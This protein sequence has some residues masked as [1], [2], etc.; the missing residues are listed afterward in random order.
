MSEVSGAYIR[1]IRDMYKGVRT[2]VRSAAGDTKY[3]PVDIGLHQ[4]SALTRSCLQLLWMSLQERFRTRSLGAC[5]LLKILFLAMS[6][7]MD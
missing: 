4:G 3:F 6:L 2:S 7:G 1:A 5:Y